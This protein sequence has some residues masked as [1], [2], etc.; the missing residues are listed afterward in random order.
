[1]T[2]QQYSTAPTP[3]LYPHN[4]TRVVRITQRL[5]EQAF[6][7]WNRLGASK[8]KNILTYRIFLQPDVWL[9]GRDSFLIECFRFVLNSLHR[10]DRAIVYIQV[11]AVW[12]FGR[13]RFLIECFRFV[14]NSLHW[15]DRSLTPHKC[16]RRL[17][18]LRES[19]FACLIGRTQSAH[20][21]SWSI[22]LQSDSVKW[23]AR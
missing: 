14:W 20:L 13:D 23:S 2:T 3:L 16:R 10:H 11:T 12:L 22:V 15:H 19:L 17:R 7:E 5:T 21:N 4:T 8:H 6:I 1:M 18:R 9:F